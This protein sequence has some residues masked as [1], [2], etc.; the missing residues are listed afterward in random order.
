MFGTEQ[1]LL[2][3]GVYQYLILAVIVQAAET[4]AGYEIVSNACRGRPGGYG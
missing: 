3:K 1:R 2:V 4:I